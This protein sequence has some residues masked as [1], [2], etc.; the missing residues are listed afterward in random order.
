MPQMADIFEVLAT[1]RNEFLRL[2]FQ[3][4]AAI[5]LQSHDEGMRLLTNIA[6]MNL[7]I[8]PVGKY[9]KPVEHPDGSTWM[10]IEVMGIKIRWP[11]K[12][13][14]QPGGGYVWQ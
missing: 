2:G 1:I 12:R 7:V 5:I 6:Q 3:P 9:G 8:D 4:P 11:A 14:A 10:E 13:F